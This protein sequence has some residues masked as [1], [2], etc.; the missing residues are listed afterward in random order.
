MRGTAD[1]QHWTHLT[2]GKWLE[3][4]NAM[5][6]IYDDDDLF[7]NELAFKTLSQ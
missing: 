2:H 3:Y 7:Y 1:T 5:I 6:A 4:N